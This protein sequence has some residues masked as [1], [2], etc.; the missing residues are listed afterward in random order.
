[1]T[2]EANGFKAMDL[3]DSKTGTIDRDL[4]T[5][6]V[7]HEI[8]QEKLFT[9][10][11]L[12]IGHE[13]QIPNPDDYFVSRMGTES[14]I[15]TR[16][17][18]GGVQVLLNTCRHRGMKVCRYDEG[19]TT[20]FAC[21]YHGWSYSTDGKLVSAPGGLLGVPQFETAYDNFDKEKW[22]LIHVAKIYNYKGTIWATWDKN[23]PDFLD[24][25]GGF[26]VYLDGVLDHRSGREGG[27]VALPGVQKWRVKCNWKFESE[28]S[29]GDLYHGISHQSVE[30]VGIGPGGGKQSRQ[31]G[32]RGGNA[33]SGLVSFPDLG[34]CAR[35]GTPYVEETYPFPE[36]VSPLGP[37]D[38]MEEVEAYYRDVWEQRQ[39]NLQGKPISWYGGHVFPNMSFHSMF[40]RDIAVVH[41]VGPNE[42]E[43]WRWCL[44]DDDAPQ[45]VID[46]ARHHFMRYVGPAGMTEQDDMEN[47]TY[48]ADA[49]KGP[50]ARRYPYNYQQGLRGALP[51]EELDGAIISDRV[52]SE[53]NARTMYRRWAQFMDADSWS[54]L[55]P[56]KAK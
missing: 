2:T 4:F 36:F 22:G 44:V 7:L 49:S 15:M 13:S 17:R 28:N 8:E 1:M 43:M 6:S 19:N 56:P 38:N 16:D 5:S 11:W 55:L 50:I 14:V 26:K 45:S 31:G 46:L 41:P 25:L 10:V 27:S 20:S 9:R 30:L 40:P 52:P 21:P 54:D 47:W 34:H 39:N 3:I 23:A 42:M 32:S 29:S 33:R 24:F 48:A 51:V 53:E 12:F 18:Q 35:G 37:L